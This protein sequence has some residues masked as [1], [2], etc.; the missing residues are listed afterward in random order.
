MKKFMLALV[1][2]CSSAFGYTP[3]TDAQGT[4]YTWN[5]T[6]AANQWITWRIKPGAE[7]LRPYILYS[8]EV[9]SSAANENIRFMEVESNEQLTIDY[10][11]P[12]DYV[13]WFLGYATIWPGEGNSITAAEIVISRYTSNIPA[14]MLHEFGH[15]LGLNHANK[16]DIIGGYDPQDL[17]TMWPISYYNATTLHQDDIAGIQALY[18]S[19]LFDPSVP[20]VPIYTI[21]VKPLRPK[22]TFLVKRTTLVFNIGSFGQADWDFG[23]GKCLLQRTDPVRHRYKRAGIYTVKVTLRGKEYFKQIEILKKRPKVKK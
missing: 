22:L 7:D 10:S 13:P 16:D 11:F 2:F 6:F 3:F 18:P 14:V 23:D 17:P 9:W 15:I 1:L 4:P 8:I 20:F 21:T 19:K 12:K 5:S